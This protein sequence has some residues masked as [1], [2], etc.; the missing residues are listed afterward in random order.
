MAAISFAQSDLNKQQQIESH[1]RQAQEFLKTNRPD[2]AAREFR[3]IL[4]LDPDNTDV[5]GNLGV[6][7]FFQGDYANAAPLLRGALTAQPTL[8]KIQALLGMCEKRIG[9]LSSA[10]TDL[11]ESFPQLQE[12]KVRIQTGTELIEVYYGAGDLDKAAGIVSVLRQLRPTDVDILYTAHRIYSDLAGETLL[13][14]AMIAPKSA[15]MHQLMAQEMLRQGNTQGAIAHYREALKIDPRVPGLHF[16]LAEVLNRSLSASDKAEVEPQYKAALAVNPFD[17]KSE[18]RLGEMASRQSDLKAAREHYSRALKLQPNDADA[19]VGL[20]KV[21]ISTNEP[22]KAE[23]L[24]ERAVQVQPFNAVIRYHLGTVYRS[25]ERTAD[26]RRELAEFQRLKKMKERLKQ[27]YQE[28][29]LEPTTQ[30]RPDPD[31]PN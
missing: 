26:S 17:E 25:L 27:V 20:A 11:E 9:Q 16:E 30:E 29:R 7:L 12:E 13:S 28:M 14:V 4:A 6:L 22:Q 3:A 8:W 10:Q 24:L 18:C 21:L 5:Q 23:A 2:L 19:N 15:R 31:V 1:S